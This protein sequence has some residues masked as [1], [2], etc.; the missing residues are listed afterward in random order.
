LKSGHWKTQKFYKTGEDAQNRKLIFE[1]NLKK[2]NLHNSN[3]SKS[4]TMK[5]NKF[6]DMTNEEYKKFYERELSNGKMRRGNTV[7]GEALPDSWDWRTKDAV[8]PVKNQG[9]CGAEFLGVLDGVESCWALQ[10]TQLIDLSIQ[11]LIDCIPGSQGCNGGSLDDLYKYLTSSPGIDSSSCYPFDGEQG[12][13]RYSQS[14]CVTKVTKITFLPP[15]EDALQAGVYA[16]PVISGVDASHASFQFYSGGVYYEP[17]CTENV[18]HLLLVVGWGVLNNQDY[19][20]A[21]NSW[22]TSWGMQGYIL[23]A[24]N[25]NNNCGIASYASSVTCTKC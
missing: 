18:D 25:E 7:N 2:I 14:C 12:S 23:M 3:E 24:R 19:W 1:E 10:S 4:Y 21:K 9:Q 16:G 15:N 6:G 11:Q 17:G 5:M 8:S 22:G 20:I 13:C